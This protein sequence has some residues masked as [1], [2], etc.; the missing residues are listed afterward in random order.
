MH[1]DLGS[2]ALKSSTNLQTFAAPELV[3]MVTFETNELTSLCPVSKQP[4]IY[5]ID[6]SY[7]PR[8]L[9]IETKSLKQY[10][11]SFRDVGIFAEDLVARIANDVFEA[12][13]ARFVT[14]QV[15][16]QVRGGIVT[17]VNAERWESAD[18]WK[19]DDDE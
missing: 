18:R 4:D 9:C 15:K 10:L 8:A 6:I 13:D 12:C 16:Q 5:E 7:H 2:G 11:W 3:S 1:Q 19:N 14:V 17:T